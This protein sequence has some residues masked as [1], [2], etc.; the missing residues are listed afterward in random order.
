MRERN[1]HIPCKSLH[2]R[3]LSL[4][5]SYSS[6]PY[7]QSSSH[8]LQPLH[9]LSAI[10]EVIASPKRMNEADN[11]LEACAK[12]KEA[13][14]HVVNLILKKLEKKLGKIEHGFPL[15]NP[16]IISIGFSSRSC[17]S[18]KKIVGCGISFDSTSFLYS[19]IQVR[20]RTLVQGA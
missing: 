6:V 11:L 18:F 13:V 12:A 7:G 15:S 20:S 16:H 3:A 1:S 2:S 19:I 4:S 17:R 9:S 14:T 10:S 8:V 5:R